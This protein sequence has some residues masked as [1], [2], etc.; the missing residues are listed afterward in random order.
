MW[1]IFERLT[2]CMHCLTKFCSR[3]ETAVYTITYPVH[4]RYQ[5][6][7]PTDETHRKTYI[8][9]PLVYLKCRNDAANDGPCNVPPRIDQ[10]FSPMTNEDQSNTL[11]TCSKV[12]W[13]PVEVNHVTEPLVAL[14]PLGQLQHSWLGTLV[15]LGTT[16]LAVS[17]L[18]G[19]V[20]KTTS[21]KCLEKQKDE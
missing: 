12:T 9:A 19:F 10:K 2:H 7:T 3:D 1:V 21:S 18:A 13:T 16:F 15:T 4:M 5:M 14:I 8:N 11:G 17:M 6:P 20:Y